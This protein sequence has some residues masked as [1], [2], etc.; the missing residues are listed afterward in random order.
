[1]RRDDRC[2][3]CGYVDP[4]PAPPTLREFV[5]WR[6]DF[7]RAGSWMLLLALLMGVCGALEW[8]WLL[9]RVVGPLFT[10]AFLWT[11]VCGVMTITDRVRGVPTMRAKDGAR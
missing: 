5:G 6:R 4:P 10:L 9:D 1:M 2:P 3:S 11:C 7:V 8:E